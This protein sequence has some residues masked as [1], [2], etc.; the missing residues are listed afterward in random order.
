MSIKPWL[1]GQITGRL[2]N[3]TQ[4]ALKSGAFPLPPPFSGH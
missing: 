3:E 4:M 1:R 2:Y